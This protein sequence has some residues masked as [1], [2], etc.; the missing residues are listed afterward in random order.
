MQD[1]FNIAEI[2]G[3][4]AEIIRAIKRCDCAYPLEISFIND[5]QYESRLIKTVTSAYFFIAYDAADIIGYAVLYANDNL[6]K[7]AYL[8][9]ICV[10]PE[11][12]GI[13]IGK[14]F[15]DIC[16][17]KAKDAGMLKMRLEV[18]FSNTKAAEFYERY[19]FK[20]EKIASD[21]S[22]YMVLPLKERVYKGCDADSFRFLE[23]RSPHGEKA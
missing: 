22:I 15:M 1:T 23:G 6:G 21:D 17:S 20:K 7:E 12:Q 18:L 11:K 5:K 4:R 9:R 2:T 10:I 3:C 16:V 13:K 8:S 14:T 19:G